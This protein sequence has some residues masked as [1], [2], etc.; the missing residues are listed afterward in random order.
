MEKNKSRKIQ[1]SDIM[2]FLLSN[3]NIDKSRQISQQSFMEL[4]K[5]K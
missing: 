3:A 5:E 4:C 1:N 2:L